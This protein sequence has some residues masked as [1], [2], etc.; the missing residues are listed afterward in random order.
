MLGDGTVEQAMG[1][2]VVGQA[3]TID[4]LS[5]RA[6]SVGNPHAVVVG[7]PDTIAEVG[8]YLE[9]HARFPNR[10]NVQVAPDRRPWRGDRARLG[11]RGG[12]DG[13]LG[14]ERG[15]GRRRDA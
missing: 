5:V 11:T 12:G 8:P 10:T 1:E 6:V 13:V 15:C 7:D 4:G 3:E 14:H 9:T 2:V